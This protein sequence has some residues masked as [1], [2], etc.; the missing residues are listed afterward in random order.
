[1][2]SSRNYLDAG[3]AHSGSDTHSGSDKLCIYNTLEAGLFFGEAEAACEAEN[4]LGE[5]G[6]AKGVLNERAERPRKVAAGG[7]TRAVNQLELIISLV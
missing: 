6:A 4:G 5:M 2:P 7:D 3:A 1:M